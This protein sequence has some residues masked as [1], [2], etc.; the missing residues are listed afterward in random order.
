MSETT[1]LELVDGV[2]MVP[3]FTR[4]KDGLEVPNPLAGEPDLLNNIAFQVPVP[5][6]VDSE[7]V[8]TTVPVVIKQAP[9]IDP[10]DPLQTRIIP[11]TRIV[12]TRAPAV[13]NVLLES[14]H[15]QR[16]DRPKTEQPRRPRGKT[17]GE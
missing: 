8:E 12:E 10:A 4:T 2:G 17:E 9:E 1:Y 3:A 7:I 6:M 16:C 11:G 14:G 13:V 15:Y 5:T